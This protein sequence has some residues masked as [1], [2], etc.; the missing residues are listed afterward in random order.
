MTL[1]PKKAFTDGEVT[2]DHY[3]IN[4]ISIINDASTSAWCTAQKAQTDCTITWGSVCTSKKC[5]KWEPRRP[6]KV[7]TAITLPDQ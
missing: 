4:L 2:C 5:V 1:V 3:R 7:C 6:P